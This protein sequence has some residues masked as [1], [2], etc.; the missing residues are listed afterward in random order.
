MKEYK[1]IAVNESGREIILADETKN[2][3]RMVRKT[4]NMNCRAVRLIPLATWGK[5]TAAVFTLDV[6]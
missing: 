6:K 3:A 1:L 2:R 4:V 5:E